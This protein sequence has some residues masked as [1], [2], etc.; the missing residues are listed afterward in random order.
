M[1]HCFCL[2]YKKH[3]FHENH[4]LLAALYKSLHHFYVLIMIEHRFSWNKC[5]SDDRIN[6][7]DGWK[8]QSFIGATKLTFKIQNIDIQKTP[9]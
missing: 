1:V 6:E 3:L 5:L 7:L 9:E 2:V 4:L 8:E